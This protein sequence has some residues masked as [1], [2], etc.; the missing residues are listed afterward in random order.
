MRTI[1]SNDSLRECSILPFLTVGCM[2]IDYNAWES[3]KNPLEKRTVFLPKPGSSSGFFCKNH[4]HVRPLNEPCL[5]TTAP[6]QN[7]LEKPSTSLCWTKIIQSGE[8]IF[9]SCGPNTP[10]VETTHDQPV[11]TPPKK[12]LFNPPTKTRDK[13]NTPWER[14]HPSWRPSSMR[15]QAGGPGSDGITEVWW[16]S[17]WF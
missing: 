8:P 4:S 14:R 3:W 6:P 10:T 7:H 5:K 15:S 11:S 9:S 13:K 17:S 12:K 1:L 2:M 16:M